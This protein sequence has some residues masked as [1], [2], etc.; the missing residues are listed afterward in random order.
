[1][2]GLGSLLAVHA[3]NAG[4]DQSRVGRRD[5]SIFQ[6]SNVPGSEVLTHHVADTEARR[7]EQI[8]WPSGSAKVD[9]HRLAPPAFYRPVEGVEVVVVFSGEGTEFARVLSPR[10]GSS[11]FSTSAPCSPRIAGAEREPTIARCPHQAPCSPLQEAA[12]L[13]HSASDLTGDAA[14]LMRAP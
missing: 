12:S 5:G 8:S 6:R 14:T 9:G 1:M 10:S 3:L 4:C 2:Q 7:T 13:S 11:I